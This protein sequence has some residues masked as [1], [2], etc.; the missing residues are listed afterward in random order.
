MLYSNTIL[1]VLINHHNRKRLKNTN[2]SLFANNCN[3][4]CICHDLNLQ[5]RSPFVNLYLT[6][7]D[8]IKFLK[9]PQKYLNEPLM[10]FNN[11]K[12]T[13]PIAKLVDIELFFLHYSSIEEAA[14]AWNRRKERICW[15]NLFVLMTDQDGC[16]DKVLHDFDSLPYKNKVVFTHIPRPDIKSSVYI[17]G[18]ENEATVGNCDAFINSWSGKKYFDAFNYVEWFNKGK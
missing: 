3:G 17:P 18:F 2:F 14:E 16:S 13:Y 12:G 6:T 15:D 7:P 8:Y 1:R 4:G 5:F 9:E 11:D 10:F